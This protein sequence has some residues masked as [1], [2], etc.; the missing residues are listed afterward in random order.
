MNT[1]EIKKQLKNYKRFVGVFPCDYIPDLNRGEGVI[2]NTDT[3]NKGGEH[4]VAI[5]MSPTGSMEYFDPFGLPPLVPHI[6]E[7]I[8]GSNHI[9]FSYSTIQLQDPSSTSCGG[10]CIAFI[11]HRLSD[12]PFEALLAHFT[13]SL[14]D[15]DK[16]VEEATK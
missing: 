11:K 14:L 9:F 8:N 4:W 10:H 1:L 5:Y 15:N 13:T 3:H 12:L 6:R 16:K 7:Y 2:V